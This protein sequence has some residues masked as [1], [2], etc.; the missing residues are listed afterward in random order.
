ME[1]VQPNKLIASSTMVQPLTKD[2]LFLDKNST[3]QSDITECD[4]NVSRLLGLP[5]GPSVFT[6]ANEQS[7]KN[8]TD[9]KFNTCHNDKEML[10]TESI[11]MQEPV[12]CSAWMFDLN[13]CS[14]CILIS[15]V[16]MALNNLSSK[17]LIINLLNTYLT[18]TKNISFLIMIKTKR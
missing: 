13:S 9:S 15:E 18:N 10:K 12:N 1:Q 11:L 4:E 17:C 6:Y 3:I 2:K 8:L 7:N 16:A 14:D 5:T